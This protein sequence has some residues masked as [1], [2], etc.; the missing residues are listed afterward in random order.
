MSN[1]WNKVSHSL[2]DRQA[3]GEGSNYYLLKLQTVVF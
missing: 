2:W 1:D 3:S